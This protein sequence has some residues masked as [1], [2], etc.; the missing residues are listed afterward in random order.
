MLRTCEHRVGKSNSELVARQFG[1][2]RHAIELRFGDRESAQVERD[3][4][5]VVGRYERD[6]GNT[7]KLICTGRVDAQVEV[8]VDDVIAGVS[9]G[10][11][12][13]VTNGLTSGDR[14]DRPRSRGTRGRVLGRFGG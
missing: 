8:I 3:L 6:G 7:L 10:R 4:V 2:D 11:V 14:D 13:G 1:L 9:N 12:V 5:D